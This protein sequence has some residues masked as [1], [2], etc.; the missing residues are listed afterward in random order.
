M[1]MVASLKKTTKM[2]TGMLTG[3]NVR[4]PLR[5]GSHQRR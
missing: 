5:V 1:N 3:I 2:N 4:R